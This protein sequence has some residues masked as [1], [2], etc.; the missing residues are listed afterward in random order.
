M[1]DEDKFTDIDGKAIFLECQTHSSFCREF[2]VSA[3]KVSLRRVMVYTC[4]VWLVAYIIFF[5]TEN[6]AVL[7]GAIFVTLVGM[8]LHIHFVKIDHE[9]LLII[10]SLGVQVSSSYASGERAPPS[11]R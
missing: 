5:I 9:T 7:S 4:S 2:T 1:A 8:M 6:T 3:P 11:S 10:G